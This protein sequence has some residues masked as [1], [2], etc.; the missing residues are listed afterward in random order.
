MRNIT[1][2]I[3]YKLQDKDGK[4]IFDNDLNIS[5]DEDTTLAKEFSK[6]NS[7]IKRNIET[8]NRIDF[9]N[10]LISKK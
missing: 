8:C 10:K 2:I 6:H 7:E 3:K 5:L 4:S 9:E 1:E